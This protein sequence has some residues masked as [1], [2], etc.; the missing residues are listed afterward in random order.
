MSPVTLIALRHLRSRHS[1]SFISFISYLS[2][3]G[4]GIGIAI[5]ILTLGILNGFENTLENKIISFDG[6]IRLT[7]FLGDPVPQVNPELD[8]VLNRIPQIVYRSPFID[9]PAV[10]R[11]RSETEG[12]YVEGIL[13]NDGLGVFGT[14]GFTVEGS[15][16]L[17]EDRDGHEGVVLGRALSEKMGA[18]VGSVVTLF[19][20][21]GLGIMGKAPRLGQ[22]RVAGLYEMGL[23]EY[24]ESVIY[25]SLPAAQRLFGYGRQISGEI[26][27]LTAA[28]LAPEVANDIDEQVGYPYSSS[29]WKDRHRNL[30]TWLSVQKYPI[31]IILALTALVAILNIMSSLT[32]IV[33]EKTRDIG[34]LRALGYSRKNV[35]GL[36]FVE[37]G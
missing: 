25:V 4:L 13:P 3:L 30:F 22:F 14:P 5:L 24:D 23:R 1:F 28:S 11:H 20:L 21:E 2:I 27:K 7:G 15:F 31:T 26:L 34:V 8:S 32:M 10:I 19:D 6:H 37:G 18:P 16:D 17:T 29:T 9:R 12:V 35:S 36:F 33:M